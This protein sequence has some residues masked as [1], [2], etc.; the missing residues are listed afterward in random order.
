MSFNIPLQW[1]WCRYKTWRNRLDTKVLLS[2]WRDLILEGIKEAM[3]ERKQ[4]FKEKRKYYKKAIWNKILQVFWLRWKWIARLEV[5]RI[6]K[7]IPDK[8]VRHHVYVTWKTWA[9]KSALIEQRVYYQWW[10]SRKTKDRT[11]I[12]LDPH[13]DSVE[14]IRKFDLAKKYFWR[15]VYIDPTLSKWNTPT[16]NPLQCW[17]TNSLDIEIQAN[18]LVMAIQEMIPDA[19]LTNFMKAILKP[20]IYVLLSLHTCSLRDIQDF[21]KAEEWERI[22]HG[23]RCKVETYASFFRN[24]RNNP[25]YLRSKQSVYTKIQSLMNSQVFY[26]MTVGESTINLE[27]AMRSGKI[28]LFNLSKW[29]IGEE[30][31]ETLGKFIIA[32]V[33]SFALQRAHLPIHLRTPIYLIIDEADTFIFKG[34]SVDTVLKEARKFG[35]HLITITQNLVAGKWQ[36]SLKRNLMNNTNVKIISNNWLST[37]KPLAQET[38]I[39]LKDLQA[40]NFH[41]FWIR[42]GAHIKKKIKTKEVFRGRSPLLLRRNEVTSM[43][44]KMVKETGYYKPILKPSSRPDWILDFPMNSQDQLYQEHYPKPKFSS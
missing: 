25:M 39:S 33:K 12:F 21:M 37:L 29:K 15:C 28:I 8:E 42:Y 16:I 9:W 2:L 41:E 23:K 34:E 17:E 30:I 20:V 7:K 19:R 18:Q 3:K 11:I 35:L 38:G 27:Q 44:H 26:H 32:Q 22:E 40:L 24:E 6:W 10:K 4:Q 5:I 43:T 1:Y 13:G 14:K 31:S 36:A